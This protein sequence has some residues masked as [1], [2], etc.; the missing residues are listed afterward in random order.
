MKFCTALVLFTT[1]MSVAAAPAPA[2]EPVAEA[3]PQGSVVSLPRR[4]NAIVVCTTGTFHDP[5]STI[6]RAVCQQTYGCEGGTIPISST[7]SWTAGCHGC[8]ANQNPNKFGNCVFA[9][10]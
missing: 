10:L 1:A 8:P 5:Q 3:A 7:G 6:V 2:P 9:S 4:V